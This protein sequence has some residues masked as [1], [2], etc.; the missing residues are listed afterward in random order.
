LKILLKGKMKKEKI[1]YLWKIFIIFLLLSSIIFL[2]ERLRHFTL[3]GRDC[4]NEPFEWGVEKVIKQNDHLSSINCYCTTLDQ[5][6][7]SD[8]LI[9]SAN[10][11][12]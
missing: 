5:K 1:E 3:E 11:K 7:L 8:T 6:G 2:G 4:I 10:R 12:E 9:F